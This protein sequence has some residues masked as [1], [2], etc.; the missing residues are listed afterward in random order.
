MTFFEN[1][2]PVDMLAAWR[3]MA[4]VGLFTISFLMMGFLKKQLG[5]LSPFDLYNSTPLIRLFAGVCFSFFMFSFHQAYWWG[6]EELKAVGNCYDSTIAISSLCD[7]RKEY[8]GFAVHLSPLFYLGFGLSATLA[9]APLL[10]LNFSIEERTGH[11]IM[12]FLLVVAMLVGYLA[13]SFSW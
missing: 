2:S 3:L 1:I 4:T 10:T 9:G 7:L 12:V 11:T 5:S 13:A 6:N 8:Y